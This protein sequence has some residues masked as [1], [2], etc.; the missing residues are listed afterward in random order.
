MVVWKRKCEYFYRFFNTVAFLG[1]FNF[2]IYSFFDIKFSAGFFV[3]SDIFTV[4]HNH[5]QATRFKLLKIH[6]NVSLWNRILWD[7][8]YTF[9]ATDKVISICEVI[10]INLMNLTRK[11]KCYST[12]QALAP[13]KHRT[14]INFLRYWANLTEDYS[15]NIKR[16]FFKH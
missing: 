9:N 5:H 8:F 12:C 4:I 1:V 3:N 11:K 10:S 13:V 14:W 16:I 2:H 6:K 15:K 7:Y